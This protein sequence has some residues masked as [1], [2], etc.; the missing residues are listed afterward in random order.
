MAPKRILIFSLAYYPQKG[1]AEVSI[2][3]LTDRITDIEFDMI[4]MC[5]N[6][7]HPRSEKVGNVN[8]YRVGN[9][10]SYL[11]KILFV[12]R[13]AFLALKLNRKNPYH[14]FWAM[15]TNMLFPITLMRLMGN[16]TLY[17]LSLQDG[18]PFEH[19]FKRFRIRIFMPLLKYGF[20]NASII[21]TLSSFLAEWP[22]K[23]GYKG[24]VEVIPNG[25][26][27]SRFS[28]SDGSIK[29]TEKIVL[30]TT[31]RLVVK[32]GVRDIIKSLN[33]LSE[34]VSLDILGRGPLEEELKSQT[35]ILKLENRVRFLGD[36]SQKDIPRYLSKADIFVRP[37]LSE[38]Q[39]ISFIEAMAAG[40]PVIT[41][42][43]GG[44]PDFLKDG[45][46]GL[47]CEIS[48][49]ESIAKQVKRLIDDKD[50][51]ARLVE[52]AKKMVI[53]KYDWNFISNEMT[54][55]VFNVSRST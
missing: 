11:D 42:P 49:P 13:A 44:I 10:A 21:Q 28:L 16:R 4:T 18:D 34:N 55:R 15:M 38:G 3:E 39:G 8:V 46:T 2:K 52:N 5:F 40:L 33:Y 50:L 22:R 47:F 36:I 27:V 7:S 14:L 20:K 54:N 48:N 9:S 19:V 30:I 43:V 31:S 23:I 32:N 45:E 25:V 51:R 12:P 24:K 37:S 1:G 53:E 41:T 6:V 29:N 35:E 17:I 26:D